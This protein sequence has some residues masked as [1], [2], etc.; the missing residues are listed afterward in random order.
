MLATSSSSSASTTLLA[1]VSSHSRLKSHG[2]KVEEVLG[3]GWIKV[4]YNILN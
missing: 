2:W 3:D 4:S 1:V